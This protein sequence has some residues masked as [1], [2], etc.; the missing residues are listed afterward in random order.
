MKVR[1]SAGQE[2]DV[3]RGYDVSTPPVARLRFYFDADL[4]VDDVIAFG[5]MV[6][7]VKVEGGKT[8][9]LSVSLMTVAGIMPGT[10]FDP[11]PLLE[12]YRERQS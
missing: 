12:A 4:D 2:I 10:S 1:V 7:K 9:P 6:D 8:T 11:T 5:I 3:H